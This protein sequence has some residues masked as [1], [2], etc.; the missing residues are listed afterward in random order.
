MFWLVTCP[1]SLGQANQ[2]RLMTPEDYRLWCKLV[3][4]NLSDNGN[5][6]SYQLLYPS[7]KDT[8]FIQ[9]TTTGKRYD[10]PLGK[11]G[12][13][14]AESDFGCIIKDTLVLQNLRLGTHR[15]IPHAY[16][17][18]FSSDQKYTILI[19][20]RS[21]G[22]YNLEIMDRSNIKKNSA[23]EVTNWYFDP[24]GKGILYSTNTGNKSSVILLTFNGSIGKRTL[25]EETSSTFQNLTWKENYIAF[26]RKGAEEVLLYAYDINQKHL[27]TLNPMQAKGFPSDLD[28]SDEP[29]HS[30]I[31]SEDG[32]HVVFWLKNKSIDVS[33]INPNTV[34]IWNTKDKLLFD[35]KKFRGDNRFYD[36]M[37]RWSVDENTVLPIQEKGFTSGFL[38]ADCR[39]A[40]IF[41][42]TAYEPQ[43]KFYSPYDLFIVDLRSGEKKCI[44]KKYTSEKIPAGSPDGKYL[45]YVKDGNWW[46]YDIQKETHINLTHRVAQSFFREDTNKPEENMPYGIGGWTKDG[47]I[48]LYDRYD[49]WRIKLDGS[50]AVRITK[51][52]EVEKTLRLREFGSGPFDSHGIE[53]QKNFLDLEK[54]FLL[55][56][57]NKETGDAGLFKWKN[58]TGLSQM[59][60]K[61]KKLT[62]F[63]KAKNKDIYLYLEQNFVSSPRLMLYAGKE[64]E[65]FQSNVQ[66]KHFY[67]SK[68][69]AI[70]Y[71]VNGVKT[72]GILFYPADYKAEKKYPMLVHIYE[73]Q[74]SYLNDYENPSDSSP[75]GFNVNH[76]TTKGY[77]VLYPD[78][79]YE[80]GNLAQSVTQSIISAVDKVVAMGMVD[81]AKIGLLG[82]SFGGY[83]TDLII[84][85]SDRFAA[86]VSGAAWTDLVSSYLYVSGTFKKP[87]FYR[88]ETNQLRIGKSLYED[89]Q[90]Y[91]KNSPVLLAQNVKTPL[92]GWAG[93]N[94]RHIHSLQSMEFYMA[95]RRLNKEH[96][97]LIYPD[98]G[99]ELSQRQNQK[100]LSSRIMEWFDYYLKNGNR[101]DWM[102]ADFR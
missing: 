26:I 93:E 18:G 35:Y 20:K 68:N 45:C 15:K 7:R 96:T 23:M 38:S 10:F 69:Q 88:A 67:W 74:F 14:N 70:Q 86:A 65:L 40:F 56:A 76:I 55:E 13:F 66:Q 1:T 42:P 12:Q 82:H 41:D 102:N 75:D 53:S 16:A 94:D 72:K 8:L 97:L 32:K 62:Q 92:L 90:S 87:D 34:Q 9:N 100:D 3:P 51:G 37:A 46:I 4:Q 24:A 83:E 25:L 21:D 50:K 6:A 63:F 73:R 95:L 22:K 11:E 98:E 17:F 27:H 71:E 49:L 52:R 29:S 99:H 64:K 30:L 61:N 58:K 101:K 80:Y 77:F 91:L 31:F 79:Q 28:I 81:P 36:K 78:I 89:M 5:W 85:Q 39:H 2:K 84:T 54:G 44:I 19:L 47:S 60:W 57:L 59:I 33:E 48:I 43:S